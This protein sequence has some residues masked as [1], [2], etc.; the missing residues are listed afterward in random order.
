MRLINLSVVSLFVVATM[1]FCGCTENGLSSNNDNPGFGISGNGRYAE[2]GMAELEDTVTVQQGTVTVMVILETKAITNSDLIEKTEYVFSNGHDTTVSFIGYTGVAM[3]LA[4]GETYTV[5]QSVLYKDGTTKTTAMTL[6]VMVGKVAPPPGRHAVLDSAYIVNGKLRVRFG[7]RWDKTRVEVNNIVYHDNGQQGPI[8]DGTKAVT[9]AKVGEYGYVTI[10]FSNF[11]INSWE[12]KTSMSQNRW[13]ITKSDSTDCYYNGSGVF[14]INWHKDGTV[15]NYN[16]S[17]QYKNAVKNPSP[18]GIVLESDSA[19]MYD[20]TQ[21]I[22]L[23]HYKGSSP[24]KIQVA[25]GDNGFL[26]EYTSS[27][28]YIGWQTFSIPKTRGQLPVLRIKFVGCSSYKNGYNS[29]LGEC[30]YY[31]GKIE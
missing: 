24:A 15:W 28:M 21:S 4:V 20:Y 8:W 27:A 5:S 30:R 3:V 18:K 6:V 1:F 7:Y 29:A 11:G 17:I 14:A 13:M 26:N 2:Y 25:W 16:S 9:L 10:E 31:V 22:S 23:L 12:F 19:L